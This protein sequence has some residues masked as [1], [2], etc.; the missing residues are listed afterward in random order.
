MAIALDSTIDGGLA[1]DTSLTFSH[2]CTG[3]NLIL[4]VG[5][6]GDVGAS[7]ANGNNVT[8]V[9]YNGIAMTEINRKLCPSD[10]WVYLFYLISPSTGAHN[11]VVSASTTIA[12]AAQSVSYTGA[13]Q[14]SQPDNSTTAT[15][16]S[17]A[18]GTDF[19]TTLSTVADNCWTI[20]A[21]KEN[22]G[23]TSAGANTT[24]RQSNTNGMAMYDSG[25]AITPPGSN[26]LNIHTSGVTDFS[27]VMASFSPAAPAVSSG[28][29]N[30]LYLKSLT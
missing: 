26:T 21:Q 22:G 30:P 14:S 28:V 13:N 3:P 11:V 5:V 4:F 24:L 2:T 7:D 17:I 15:G 9:T 18:S 19:G 25:G 29:I 6:F 1:V 23:V 8:G 12:M 10:R 16:T 20:I 27:V